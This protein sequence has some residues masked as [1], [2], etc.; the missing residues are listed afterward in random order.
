MDKEEKEDFEL[1]KT[2]TSADDVAEIQESLK[3]FQSAS[4][5][6][7]LRFILSMDAAK[8]TAAGVNVDLEQLRSILRESGHDPLV[9]RIDPQKD[10]PQPARFDEDELID[11]LSVGLDAEL[12][13]M[14][15]H[16]AL[17]HEEVYDDENE[18]EKEKDGEK[19]QD[20]TVELE[21]VVDIESTKLSECSKDKV[22]KP[23]RE[24]TKTISLDFDIPDK[25]EYER[26]KRRVLVCLE[27]RKEL[28][29]SGRD[30]HI[31]MKEVESEKYTMD[32]IP[33]D[34]TLK[35]CFGDGIYRP[36][37]PA[38]AN[39]AVRVMRNW[40]GVL[41][42]GIFD[43]MFSGVLDGEEVLVGV[44]FDEDDALH[45]NLESR[46]D[47]F[48]HLWAKGLLGKVEIATEIPGMERVARH[49]GSLWH[50][51]KGCTGWIFYL[52]SSGNGQDTT[53]KAT[54]EEVSVS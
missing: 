53:T 41:M 50:Q 45:F 26:R 11:T 13:S 42:D 18:S 6:E 2:P 4:P 20:H 51:M 22:T 36:C 10:P 37:V 17:E 24:E 7:V 27:K 8:L 16:D 3:D 19:E 31:K 14:F 28:E 5:D 9:D 52:P 21:D 47:R 32:V 48:G 30:L 39:D 34:D 33:Q 38:I 15:I 29:K 49:D 25:S 44:V 40:T 23:M 46:V 35:F 43:A 1:R 12:E 54:H